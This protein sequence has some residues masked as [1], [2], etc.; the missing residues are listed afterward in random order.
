MLNILE[1]LV[2]VSD[3]SST[4]M[5]STTPMHQVNC[6]TVCLDLVQP[7]SN[8]WQI[9]NLRCPSAWTTAISSDSRSGARPKHRMEVDI[10]DCKDDVHSTTL[11]SVSRIK[12]GGHA[13]LHLLHCLA[14]V[15]TAGR[16]T[17]FVLETCK[18]V[19]KKP[20]TA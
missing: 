5:T 11:A 16:T 17:D 1:N 7:T 6:C 4:S 3:Q 2:T 9:S 8:Y 18:D 10:C 20:R 13:E 19:Q 15:R 12:V 14:T